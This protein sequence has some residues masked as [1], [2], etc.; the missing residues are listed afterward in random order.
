V[1]D[2]NGYA[3]DEFAPDEEA[4]VDE[5]KLTDIVVSTDAY[6]IVDLAIKELAADDTLYQR[7]GVLVRVLRDSSPAAGEEGIRRAL[8]PRIDVVPVPTLLERLTKVC[9][10]WELNKKGELERVL[11]PSWCIQAVA[12]RGEWT[13]I[14]YLEC[15]VDHPVLRP[16]GT[17][18]V[19]PGYDEQTGLLFESGSLGATLKRKPTRS[20]AVKAVATLY[21]VVCDFP[22][23]QDDAGSCKAAWLAALLTPLARFAFEGPSPLFLIDGNTPGAGKGLLLHSISAI[24]TGERFTV[25]SYTRDGDELRKRITSLAISGERMVLFDNLSGL[26]GDAVLDAALTATSWTDRLLGQN[27]MVRVPLYVTWYATGNNVQIGGDTTRRTCYIRLESDREDPESRDDFKYPDLLSYVKANRGKLLAAGLTILQAYCDA[28]RPNQ[29]LHPWGS[30]EGWSNLVR[31]A[32]AWATDEDPAETR[33]MLEVASD[34]VY[35]NMSVVLE[36]LEQ[37]DPLGRGMFAAEIIQ[38]M[39][40]PQPDDSRPLL[41]D[42][43]KDALESILGKA[44]A[45]TLGRKLRSYRR[46]VFNGRLIDHAPGSEHKAARWLVQKAKPKTGKGGQETSNGRA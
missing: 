28:G 31:Q 46:R 37:M 38:R 3:G 16:D 21:D 44:D 14:P 4:A 7:G 6:Q 40:K 24:L 32:V 22:F 18:L 34:T 35:G 41:F 23:A 30:F 15:V 27:R 17:L 5:K 20:D 25:A 8:A 26:F 39:F 13:G 45:P 19:S 12:A 29:M 10:W 11:P 36:C 33:M 9:H 43:C 2:D 42:E 1:D